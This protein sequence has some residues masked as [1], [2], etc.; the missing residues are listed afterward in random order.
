MQ[1]VAESPAP[2]LRAVRIG[3]IQLAVT[4]ALVGLSL[5]TG[6]G[7]PSGIIGGAVLLY[8]SLLLQSLAVGLVLRPGGRP[9]IGLGLFLLKLGLLLGVALIGLRTS[10]LAPMSFAAG[11]TTLLLAIVID[12]CYGTRSTSS[13]P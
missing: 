7:A 1:G 13:P 2:R 5:A 4:A 10:L 8:A 3:L 11:A 6:R 12:T 9:A